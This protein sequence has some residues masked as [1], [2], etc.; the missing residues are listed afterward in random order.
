MLQLIVGVVESP[1]MD[2]GDG[3]DWVGVEDFLSRKANCLEWL[4]L[5]VHRESDRK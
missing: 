3:G 4:N 5:D 2:K 1:E